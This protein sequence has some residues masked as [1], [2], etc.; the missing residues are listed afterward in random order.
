MFELNIEKEK[1]GVKGSEDWENPVQVVQLLS[2][3]HGGPR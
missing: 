1:R 3:R 2:L